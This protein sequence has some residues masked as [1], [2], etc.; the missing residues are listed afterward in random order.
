MT[1]PLPQLPPMRCD[2]GCE[3]CCGFVAVN[4]DEF[5]RIRRIAGAMGVTP[6]RSGT[7]CPLYIDGRCSVYHARPLVCRLFGHTPSLNCPRGYNVNIPREDEL[8]WGA[9]VA[10]QGVFGRGGTR[11]L[12]EL[13]Y[14]GEEILGILRDDLGVEVSDIRQIVSTAGLA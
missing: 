10:D 9:A 1:I 8:R 5:E 3:R 7:R 12:H 14:S 13:V 4:R 2:P 11:L 6:Q